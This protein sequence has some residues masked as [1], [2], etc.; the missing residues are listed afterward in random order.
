L[1]SN[2]ACHFWFY[3][4]VAFFD[5]KQISEFSNNHYDPEGEIADYDFS[6]SNPEEP[7]IPPDISTESD[8]ALAL[9]G[10]VLGNKLAIENRLQE[11]YGN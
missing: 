6:G 5:R 9:Q 11:L 2:Q 3:V 8:R 1:T 7:P 10:I 4:A